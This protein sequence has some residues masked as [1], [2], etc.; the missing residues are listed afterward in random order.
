MLESFPLVGAIILI[1]NILSSIVGFRDRRFFESYSFE[2]NK[3]RKGEYYRLLTSGFLHV[4]TPHLIFN[5]VTLYFFVS[6]VTYSL[7]A[8]SFLILYFASLIIGNLLTLV[9][10]FNQSN[11]SAVGASGAV[12]GILFS[13]LLLFPSIEL[14]IFFI[15]IPIPGY[16]FGIGYILYT[17]YGIG[18]QNDNI[19]HSAHFG[20]AVGG[21]ILTLFYDFDVIYNSKLMLSILC[22]TILV[23][24]Y[25]LY[26]KKNKN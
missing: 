3:I 12:T 1:I 17:I 5:M 8:L 2:I 24:G 20:G 10:H 21:V 25:L 18:A 13:S 22:L 4:N 14:M 15:P 23:A 6:F 16:I 7:G 9:I 11:Y 26:D 19:G